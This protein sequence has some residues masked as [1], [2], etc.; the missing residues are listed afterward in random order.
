M[1]TRGKPLNPTK[2]HVMV[3]EN[4]ATL[5]DLAAEYGM[6]V[7]EFCKKARPVVG[8][9]KFEVLKRT[10]MRN[11]KTRKKAQEKL[12]KKNRP[13]QTQEIPE[14]EESLKEKIQKSLEQAKRK[15]TEEYE[16]IRQMFEICKSKEKTLAE[17]E[18]DFLRAKETLQQAEKAL[19]T[20]REEYENARK[21][22]SSHEEKF[23]MWT[24]Q[25]KAI[26][27]KLDELHK[28]D[29]YLISPNY[30]GELPRVG[31]FISTEPISGVEIEIE[32]GT[33]LIEEPLHSTD[34]PDYISA[35]EFAKLV[36]K[37]YLGDESDQVTILVN[38]DYY[39]KI[40]RLQGIE[41]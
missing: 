3:Y 21:Q 34:N 23:L 20:A 2:I 16:L 4:G 14:K 5:E 12:E 35:L 40:L 17:A 22:K 9:R 11:H 26:Q 15:A 33:E 29:I 1:N 41:I 36:L 27:R 30:T 10:C 28:D 31:R 8:T 37:Y 7:E 25:R 24:K 32:H 19:Q 39:K 13:K 18:Q 38:D 6:S